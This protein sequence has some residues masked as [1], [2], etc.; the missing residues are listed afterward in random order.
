[1][2]IGLGRMKWDDW[3]ENKSN[4]WNLCTLIAGIVTMILGYGA[5]QSPYLDW[6]SFIGAFTQFGNVVF[7]ELIRMLNNPFAFVGLIAMIVGLVFTLNNI[8]KL[9]QS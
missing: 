6:T 1:M 4:L 3:Y 8:K 9:L 7:N 2:I 5:W